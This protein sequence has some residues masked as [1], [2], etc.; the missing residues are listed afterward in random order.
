MAVENHSRMSDLSIRVEQ[1]LAIVGA[2][3]V[4]KSSLLRLLNLVLGSTVGQLYS[5][6]SI[7]DLRDVA[8]CLRVS[9]TFGDF[10]DTERRLFH[11]EIDVAP[12]DGSESLE[13]RL[14][15]AANAD[16]PESVTVTRWCPGGGDVRALTRDQLECLGW[17][18]MPATRASSAAALDGPAGAIRVLLGAVEGDL[19]SEKAALGKFLVDFNDNLADSNAISAL[20]EQVAGHLSKAMPRTVQKDDLAVRTAT[21]PED[22][23]LGTVSLFTSAPDGTFTPLFEQ[24]DGVRQLTAITLFDLA[25]SAAKVI[26]IDEP[27][28]HLHPPSQRTLARLLTEATTQKIVVTHSP[29]VVHRFDPTQVVAISPDGI[30]RQLD[31]SKP[32]VTEHVHA[33]WWSPR[34]LEALTCRTAVLVEGVA[35]RLIVEAAAEARGLSLDRTG[36]TVF[37]LGGAE[38]F[39]HVY[40]LL[41][42]QGFGV[43]VLGLVDQA[44]SASWF[45]AVGGKPKNVQGATIFVCVNDLE[46]EYCRGIGAPEVARRLIASMPRA[47]EVGILSACGA[48]DV[49]D[50]AADDL[51]RFC[52]SGG[53]KI[54]AALAVAS[55]MTATDV[56]RL[57][58]VAALLDRIAALNT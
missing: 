19:G 55:S 56:P 28:L 54:P 57:G 50:L 1:H 6:L 43:R 38:N 40:G 30:C 12:S 10:D 48:A 20:R 35:D 18:F 5:A 31:G 44:E 14:E 26:A 17:R 2:N 32:V 4:G 8:A 29:Y 21:D 39:R 51:A 34:M 13:V 7:K 3:D 27:E 22:S 33:H 46:D 47:R 52:R 9:V 23:V 42:P 36:V 24:S 37:E 11:R 49:Q 25:E 58:A 16:D 53:R 45:G 41:G 15:V